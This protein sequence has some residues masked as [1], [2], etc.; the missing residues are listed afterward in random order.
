MKL[1]MM[2]SI[3]LMSLL[4]SRILLGISLLVMYVMNYLSSGTRLL[5]ANLSQLN[6]VFPF[7]YM[8][9]GWMFGL[10]WGLIFILLAVWYAVGRK[11]DISTSEAEQ[12][13]RREI[14]LALVTIILNIS[15]LIVMGQERYLL[16]A[17]IIVALMVVLGMLVQQSRLR[18]IGYVTR[19][20]YYGWIT[21]ATVIL[22]SSIVLYVLQGMIAD[23]LALT[24]TWMWIARG[25]GLIAV[26]CS[27]R[28]YRSLP[29]LVWS[30]LAMGTS[31][32][33]FFG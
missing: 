16:A 15:W 33:A 12:S 27:Y 29:A 9:P 14:S 2:F 11:R 21:V 13:Y 6:A 28:R 22:T 10:S 26:L 32:W 8:P 5:G 3:L 20:I 1:F 18:S 23:S 31:A 4:T 25:L 24:S 19:G 30:L 7:D 17:V